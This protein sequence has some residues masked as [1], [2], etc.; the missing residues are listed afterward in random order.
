MQS[1]QLLKPEIKNHSYTNTVERQALPVSFPW[2]VSEDGRH[3]QAAVLDERAL[4]AAVMLSDGSWLRSLSMGWTRVKIAAWSI[5]LL[6]LKNMKRVFDL[7]V[8]LLL[9]PLL[10][11]LMAITALAIKL[12]SQGPVVFKQPRVGKWGKEFSCYKFRSM[13]VDAEQR[14]AA[15][16]ALNEADEVVFKM[17]KDPRITRVGRIIRKLS[18]DELPQLFNVMEGT[19]SLVGPRPPVPYEVRH[20]AFDQMHRLEV[21][22]G[23]TGLQQVSGRSDLPFK[24][25]IALDLRYI[26]QQSLRKD[27]EILVRTIPAVITGRGAY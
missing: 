18:I 26:Q 22:P 3:F 17:K 23:I 16:A 20:Y 6:A 9:L 19:M 21:T 27:I 1:T 12:D 24:Q 8:C 2:R 14:K 5:R 13:Y 25:W 10:L 15:L 4:Q 7:G 11:P